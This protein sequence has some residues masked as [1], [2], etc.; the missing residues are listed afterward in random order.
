M[1]ELTATETAALC[2][3]FARAGGL[4]TPGGKHEAGYSNSGHGGPYME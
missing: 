1:F 4:E 3:A 2:Q